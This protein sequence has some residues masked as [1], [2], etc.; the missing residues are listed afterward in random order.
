MTAL[1]NL[2]PVLPEL[3]LAGATLALLMLGVFRG[4]GATRSLSWLAVL[5][6]VVTGVVLSSIGGGRTVTFSGQFVIDGFAVFMKWLVLIGSALAILMSL[7]FNE[8]EGMARAEYPVLVMFATLGMFLMVSANDLISLYVGLE[9]QSLALYVVA[10]FHRDSLRSSEAGLKYFVLGALA[11]GILLY[12]ASLVYGFAGS[13]GF[14]ALAALFKRAADGGPPV[15]LVI[16]LVFVIAGLAFKISA[17]PFH[18]WTPDV[19]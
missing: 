14:D 5:A 17:V 6:L 12:G 16:G 1:P 3:V 8:R 9:L 10:A 15:G 19:Y 11:S 4:D 18:M 2:M 13:T 7:G